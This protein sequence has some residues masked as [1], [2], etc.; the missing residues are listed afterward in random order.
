MKNGIK[1]GGH[2]YSRRIETTP[3]ESIILNMAGTKVV[4]RLERG[5]RAGE[6]HKTKVAQRRVQG[7][8]IVKLA[9]LYR[10]KSGEREAEAQP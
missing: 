7:S 5:G 2:D 10:N 1:G 3:E 6:Q 8:S 9:E 4:I